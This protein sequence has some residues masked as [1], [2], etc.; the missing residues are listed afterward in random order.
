MPSSALRRWGKKI[1][2]SPSISSRSREPLVSICDRAW[3]HQQ[4]GRGKLELF[5]WKGAVPVGGRFQQ[6]MVDACPRTIDRIP[7]N[8]DLLRDLV[9]GRKADHRVAL[10]H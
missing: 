4:F 7:W 2:G 5:E 6:N 8:P 10:P 3:N 9:G 1:S